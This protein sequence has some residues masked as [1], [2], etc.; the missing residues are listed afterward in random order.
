MPETYG[1]GFT[2]KELEDQ[3]V[4]ELP[5]RDLLIGVS[6]LGIPL[7]GVDGV[8]VNIDTAGPNW[9]GSIGSL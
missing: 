9:L 4:A 5:S 8:T 7:V 1:K 6:L 3:H 2:T